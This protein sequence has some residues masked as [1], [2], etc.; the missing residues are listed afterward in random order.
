MVHVKMEGLLSVWE[1]G[2]VSMRKIY[3]IRKFYRHLERE[4]P[5]KRRK[6]KTR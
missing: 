4:D 1:K 2:S 6:W 3:K 5:E